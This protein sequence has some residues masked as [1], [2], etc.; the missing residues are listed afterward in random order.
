MDNSSTELIQTKT[1]LQCQINT[2]TSC[3][4][5]SPYTVF[6]CFTFSQNVF[7]VYISVIKKIKYHKLSK[8][9]TD[10]TNIIK[11][12]SGMRHFQDNPVP[13]SGT[14]VAQQ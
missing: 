12:L 6:V 9:F 10:H 8:E 13:L 4:F 5:S 11:T 7:P 2:V 3:L 1:T 14:K